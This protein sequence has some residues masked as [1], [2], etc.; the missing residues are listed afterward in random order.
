MPPPS[1]SS[2]G[3]SSEKSSEAHS[4]KMSWETS[5]FAQ[6]LAAEV[7]KRSWMLPDL[8]ETG[9][10]LGELWIA[11]LAWW[12]WAG[13]GDESKIGFSSRGGRCPPEVA[14]DWNGRNVSGVEWVLVDDKWVLSCEWELTNI[15]C[16]EKFSSESTSTY[17]Y[18]PN[19]FMLVTDGSDDIPSVLLWSEMFRFWNTVCE[20]MY[21]YGDCF[22]KDS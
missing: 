22:H 9:S 14:P 13:E 8:F 11:L 12:C 7:L 3:Y 1:S 18:C 5:T 20:L 21:N 16:M 19:S 4:S 2:S 17:S 10:S 15:F 6:V